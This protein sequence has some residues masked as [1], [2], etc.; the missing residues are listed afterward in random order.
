MTNSEVD[1]LRNILMNSRNSSLR[2]FFAGKTESQRM[3][4]AKPAIAIYRAEYNT[5]ASV[6]NCALNAVLIT[7]SE[8]QLEKLTY[9]Y[10][11]AETVDLDLLVAHKPKTLQRWVELLIFRNSIEYSFIKKLVALG[12]CTRPKTNDYV[13]L[14]MA[15]GLYVEDLRGDKQF[16]EEYVWRFFEI[17]GSSD[18]NLAG[19]E[20]S[21]WRTK[22]W[23][24][25]LLELC[26]EGLLSR[27][28]LIDSCLDALDRGFPQRRSIWFTYF[29]DLLQPTVAERALRVKSYANLLGSSIPPTVAFALNIL[30]EIDKAQPLSAELV[31]NNFESPLMSRSKSVVNSAISLIESVIKRESA[32]APKLASLLLRALLHESPEIQN[33]AIKILSKLHLSD[34]EEFCT[35]LSHY[36]EIV[37]ASARPKLVEILSASNTL[38]NFVAPIAVLPDFE[39]YAEKQNRNPDPLLTSA[40]L[41]AFDDIESLL[42]HCSY[43]MEHPDEAM[44]MERCIEGIVRF[45][46]ES[47]KN[48]A[49]R[50]S[51]LVKRAF[52]IIESKA[53]S[54]EFTQA[55]FAALVAGWLTENSVLPN[56]PTFEN[57]ARVFLIQRISVVL[58]HVVQRNTLPLLST[59]THQCGWI[60]PNAIILRWKL[61]N[62][63][64]Q[65]PDSFDQSV[66]LLRMPLSQYDFATIGDALEGE[67][68]DAM[69]Y[70]IGK[71]ELNDNTSSLLM[72]AAKA[73]R[74]PS[75]PPV[76]MTLGDGLQILK[77]PSEL[78][79]SRW[80]A[81]CIPSIRNQFVASGISPVGFSIDAAGIRYARAYVEV[82]LDPAFILDRAAHHV[83]AAALI[84]ADHECIGLARDIV[85]KAI[86]EDRLN[87]D[88]LGKEIAVLL[89]SSSGKGKRLAASFMDVARISDKHANAILQLVERTLQGGEY[90]PRELQAVLEVLN[91]LLHNEGAKLEN[92]VT[93]A[94]LEKISSGGKSGKLIKEIL[95]K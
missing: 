40:K 43:C 9:R 67:F 14:L 38:N 84:S 69:R 5:S 80:I 15:G 44:E 79:L 19:I 54:I 76:A 37:A 73:V 70:A 24:T 46:G 75:V 13:L 31:L 45:C 57:S 81:S 51:P 2:Q 18:T 64:N 58:K 48:F 62:K 10:I 4:F 16:L 78:G 59:P 86:D 83:L 39:R 7:A 68:W 11:A 8:E 52:S 87:I 17:E 94:Y 89:Y 71:S 34:N 30:A 56:L 85:I 65:S 36:Q 27:E 60:D 6:S 23:G 33:K 49:N 72:C 47:P 20:K 42:D 3:A 26:N 63:A 91:E 28:R 92:A 41:E 74:T 90:P 55:A 35:E 22:H 77:A 93:R 88:G 95:K 29:H 32:A 53:Q 1:E 25:V 21:H 12:L 82:M 61:W 50:A 66:A